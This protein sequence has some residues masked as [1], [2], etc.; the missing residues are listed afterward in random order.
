MAVACLRQ[1]RASGQETD[2]DHRMKTPSKIQQNQDPARKE[3]P[4]LSK[5]LRKKPAMERRR[6]EDA[7]EIDERELDKISGGRIY[8]ID[9]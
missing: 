3:R 1:S 2:E 6:A 9:I 4:L 7:D 8:R 5:L